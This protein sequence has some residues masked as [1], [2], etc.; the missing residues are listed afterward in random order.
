MS[1]SCCRASQRRSDPTSCISW[2][3]R[4][5]PVGNCACQSAQ[6]QWWNRNSGLIRVLANAVDQSATNVCTFLY[7]LTLNL[8][9]RILNPLTMGWNTL[10]VPFVMSDTFELYY[11]I[12]D[13]NG[14]L[15]KPM[16]AR[17]FLLLL[18]M[19]QRFLCLPCRMMR[20][21]AR[22]GHSPVMY[23]TN[24][25]GVFANANHGI[26]Y[27]TPR[28]VAASSD[29]R[30]GLRR[31]GMRRSS[32]ENSLDSV[33]MPYGY[34]P[35]ICCCS[36][37]G[38][39]G[40]L[41]KSLRPTPGYGKSESEVQESCEKEYQDSRSQTAPICP[42]RSLS[43]RQIQNLQMK[44]LSE[45]YG[46][47]C[48]GKYNISLL[49]RQNTPRS[50][51]TPCEKR[52]V[53]GGQ[54]PMLLQRP[55]QNSAEDWRCVS[56]YGIQQQMTRSVVGDNR[57]DM[58]QRYNQTRDEDYLKYNKGNAVR[59][60]SSTDSSRIMS[61]RS[62]L[63]AIEYEKEVIRRMNPY[64]RDSPSDDCLD[65]PIREAIHAAKFNKLKSLLMRI[66]MAHKKPHESDSMLMQKRCN[67]VDAKIQVD[68]NKLLCEMLKRRHASAEKRLSQPPTTKSSILTTDDV[69]KVER[70]KRVRFI[71]SN[72]E[73]YQKEQCVE[74]GS[75]QRIVK[76]KDQTMEKAGR[77]KQV[78]TRN[79][80]VQPNE[81]LKRGHPYLEKD[82]E[83]K[84]VK[85][86]ERAFS[87]QQ[88]GSGQGIF[89]RERC[90]RSWTVEDEIRARKKA[91]NGSFNI[92]F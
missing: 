81:I 62:R 53:E 61:G 10:K 65:A 80:N 47:V 84:R 28:K 38:N 1:R 88:A 83:Q 4:M 91:A 69:T 55:I 74:S 6:E 19:M 45:F 59:G 17:A 56:Q 36:G 72:K 44:T 70:K 46:A 25:M 35:A 14:D 21:R 78:N 34:A 85:P 23:C 15:R 24:G 22:C 73:S 90:D 68:E 39:S 60:T 54:I 49:D 48:Q 27:N 9:S 79:E 51:I 57:N 58:L 86:A 42:E 92:R 3:P 13:E 67:P 31:L 71:N 5:D 63:L 64:M 82:Y 30:A 20:P 41:P 29:I 43:L 87:R 52:R 32:S 11:G 26:A 89:Y 37:P 77:R 75:K 2:Y 8:F 33:D 50:R 40:P 66:T 12:F 16:P 7:Q 18:A 76:P